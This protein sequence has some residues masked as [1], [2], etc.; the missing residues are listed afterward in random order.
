MRVR[1]HILG[2]V[3]LAGLA[4]VSCLKSPEVVVREAVS[5]AEALYGQGQPDQAVAVLDK[6]L[7][8]KRYEAYHA[9]VRGVEL[10]IRIGG[11]LAKGELADAEA[12]LRS[13]AAGVPDDAALSAMRAVAAAE[14][15]AAKSATAD[16]LC[17]SVVDTFKAR[18]PLREGAAAT[19]LDLADKRGATH[20]LMTRIVALKQDG[21]PAT[22]IENRI[23]LY[24]LTVLGKTGK[25]DMAALADCLHDLMKSASDDDS[26]QRL[27]GVLLDLSFYLE[28]FDLAL[29]LLDGGERVVGHD[30]KWRQMMTAKVKGHLALQ[31]GRPTEAVAHFREFMGYIAAEGR[32]D[33]DPV[34]QIHVTKE[35]ILGLNARRIGDILAG[36]GDKAGAAKAYAEARTYYNQ[37]LKDFPAGT[38]ENKKIVEDLRAIPEG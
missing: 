12:L 33:I 27:A 34:E 1:I 19:W 13:S 10:N 21:F 23:G 20:E 31:K 28:R 7:R 17:R 37:A 14:E 25:E 3:L 26:R 32:S 30:E 11:R 36:A 16:A 6:I 2:A 35:M 9:L 5:A 18:E 8:N 15:H 22:F 4:S 29:E 38:P 24:Y